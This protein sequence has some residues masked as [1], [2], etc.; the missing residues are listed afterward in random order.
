MP[1]AIGEVF[2]G[3]VQFQK[4]AEESTLLFLVWGHQ[5]FTLLNWSESGYGTKG[6]P[7]SR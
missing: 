2:E 3:A 7:S 6:C 1:T 5:Y 4:Y